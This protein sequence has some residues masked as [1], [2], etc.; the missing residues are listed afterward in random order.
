MWEGCYFKCSSSLM[1]LRQSL[2]QMHNRSTIFFGKTAHK[3]HDLSFWPA[4]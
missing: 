3:V 2:R 1:L 4:L